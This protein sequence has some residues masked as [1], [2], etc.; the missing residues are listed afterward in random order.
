MKFIIKIALIS[1]V[2]SLLWSCQK[3]NDLLKEGEMLFL[4][5][6]GASMPVLVRGK[7]D[8]DAIILMVHGGAGGSSAPHIEDLGG[9]VEKEFMVAY[10]D[11]RHSGSS[12]GNFSKD[13][14]TI[15]QFSEDMKYVVNML[16]N[17]YGADK[18]IFAM[19][20]S[21]GVILTT[22]YLITEEVGLQGVI[23][24]NG[25][26]SSEHEYSARMDYVHDF[27]QEMIEKGLSMPKTIKVE[28]KTFTTLEEVVQWTLQNDPIDNWEQLTIL[29]ELVYSV[30]DYVQDTYVQD[31]S[32]GL[33]QVSKSEID[34]YSPYNHLN[35]WTN[36]IRTSQLMNSFTDHSSIQEFYDFTP[37]M[38]KI[39]LPTC[40]IW[41]KYDD[42]IGL[43]VAYDYYDVINTPEEDKELII[44]EHSDHIGMYLENMKFS[45]ALID[46]V[47]AHK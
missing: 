28:G 18:K 13:L 16:K 46:F 47:K 7:Y 35:E 32:D 24:S 2:L 45:N 9:L 17:K 30:Y 22:H 41:G 10:W 15:E 29:N 3:E 42:I 39:T 23:L 40:L 34:F 4:K 1:L 20:H 44:L 11:Q 31:E 8:S 33:I 14:M 12:Q 5:H 36:D 25:A 38:D 37:E 19:G 43:E 26:H 27:A 21:W 6:K